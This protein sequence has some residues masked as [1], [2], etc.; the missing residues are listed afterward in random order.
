MTMA[1]SSR[2]KKDFL[3]LVWKQ[4]ERGE[5]EHQDTVEKGRRYWD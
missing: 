3:A 1:P 2:Y 4:G 5:Q